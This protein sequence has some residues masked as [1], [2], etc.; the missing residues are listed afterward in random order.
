MTLSIEEVGARAGRVLDAV[1]Q[2]V[3]GKRPVLELVLIGLLA[4]GHVLIEDVPGL[5]KTMI[6][7]TLAQATG[8]D[9]S[10]IQF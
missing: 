8:L 4:N 3:V 5:A 2:V 10:R 7:R 9:F 6:A 1:E